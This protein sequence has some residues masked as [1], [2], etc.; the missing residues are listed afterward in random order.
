MMMIIQMY[1]LIL[2]E[3]PIIM[4]Y[5]LR[6]KKK[7]QLKEG[8]ILRSYINIKNARRHKEEAPYRNCIKIYPLPLFVDAKVKLP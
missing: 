8:K 3:K 6:Q 4:K 1:F 7:R 2:K 5:V